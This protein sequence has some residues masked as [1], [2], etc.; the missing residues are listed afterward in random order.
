MHSFWAVHYNDDHVT[1]NA[2][3]V[4]APWPVA[5]AF[6]ARATARRRGLVLHVR[7]RPS[8]GAAGARRELRLADGAHDF[9]RV[10]RKRA[11]GVRRPAALPD[12]TDR[13]GW[14]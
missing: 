13:A 11:A 6:G 8:D 3:F 14:R 4:W 1:R 12:A 5:M 9:L 10:P 2:V 7:Q